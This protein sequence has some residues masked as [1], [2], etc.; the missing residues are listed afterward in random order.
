M[1]LQFAI[2]G[3]VMPFV[4]I[5]LRDAGLNFEQIGTIFFA[6][7]STLLVFPFLWGMLA[8]RYLPLNRLFT[9]LNALSL[10]TLAIFALQQNYWGL[11]FSFTALYAA[12]NPT[13]SLINPL[14]FHHL[15]DP[16]SQFGRLRAWGS[17]GWIVPSLP[18]YLWLAHVHTTTGQV[19]RLTFVL[20]LG[21]AFAV[22]M[23]VLSFWLPHTP[24]GARR[25]GTHARPAYWPALK[26][27]LTD[28][29]YVTLLAAFFLIAASYS[30]YFYYSPP[31]LEDLGMPR[32]WIGPIQSIGVLVEIAFFWWQP[33]FIRKWSYRTPILVGC[34]A[35]MGRHLTCALAG[36][37]W[38]I[39][40][41]YLL[42]GVVIVFFHT[43]VSVLVNTIARRE[44]R[45]TAQTLL[46]FFGSG[47]GPMF[48]NWVAGRLAT[49]PTQSLR[50]VFL[51]AAV[52]AGLASL[53][54]FVRGS[55]L[56]K[57]SAEAT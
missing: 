47:M 35:L 32:A 12:Y 53:L 52:L 17:I 30:L 56:E 39:C 14:S 42:A 55:K 1:I 2:G 13:L 29:N 54:I 37:I 51:F 3:A 4:S 5:R 9:V 26:A 46:V 16:A 8:D 38:V 11:L 45:S 40:L 6:S 41:S 48:S 20:Y 27:L 43:R 18:T 23:L 34:L 28:S 10:V 57:I 22:A 21:L 44:V 36:S 24:A 25:Q 31:F 33:P 50:P 15:S 19:P 49:N 7:S